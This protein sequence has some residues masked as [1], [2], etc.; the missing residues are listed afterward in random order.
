MGDQDTI[1]Q[2][3]SADRSNEHIKKLKIDSERILHQMFSRNP[4]QEV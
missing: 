4:Q 1:M 2:E 3:I